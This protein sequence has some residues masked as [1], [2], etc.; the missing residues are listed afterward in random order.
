[1]R[2]E[3][4]IAEDRHLEQ[5]SIELR[6]R[7]EQ[8]KSAYDR[9]VTAAVEVSGQSTT[10]AEI[11][12]QRRHQG[13]V[14]TSYLKSISILV[15]RANELEGAN[16]DVGRLG[17]TSRDPE[18]RLESIKLTKFDGDYA[19]W[20]EWKSMYDSLIHNRK[21]LSETE[22]FHYLRKSLVG[23]KVLAGWHTAEQI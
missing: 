19:R 6:S 1:M 12:R 18:L 8:L 16:E 13:A 9:Y 14:E 17:W 7:I 20:T 3:A 2:A 5:S 10:E 22:K 11:E 23:E 15:T 4:F 21:R